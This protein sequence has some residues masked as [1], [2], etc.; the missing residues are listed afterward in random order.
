M[1]W[2][3]RS[4]SRFTPYRITSKRRRCLFRMGTHA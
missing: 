3:R 1:G 4:L 2:C